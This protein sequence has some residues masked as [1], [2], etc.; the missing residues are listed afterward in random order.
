M[1]VHEG[2]GPVT[3]DAYGLLSGVTPEKLRQIMSEAVDNIFDKHFGK[4]ARKSGY[5]SDRAS[6]S[7]PRVECSA[8]TS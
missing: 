3:Q 4:K 1:A 7:K 2:S 6:F 5:E 8:A